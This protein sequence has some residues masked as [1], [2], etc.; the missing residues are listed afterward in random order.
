M[1]QGVLGLLALVILWVALAARIWC[2]GGALR[3]PDSPG[4][5]CQRHAWRPRTPPHARGLPGLPRRRR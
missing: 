5:A 1:E 4:A 2:R 3:R